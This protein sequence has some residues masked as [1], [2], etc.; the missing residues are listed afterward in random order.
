[1]IR[2]DLPFQAFGFFVFFAAGVLLG[3]AYDILR[4]WRALF[5]SERRSVFFQDF[6]FMGL[7][8]LFTFL[9][10]LAVNGGELRLFLFLSEA[11]GWVVWF[12]TVGRVT[13]GLFRK[14]SLFLYRSLFDPLHRQIS[15]AGVQMCRK[16]GKI[17]A[18]LKKHVQN[19]KKSLKRRGKQVYNKRE[20]NRKGVRG[21]NLHRSKEGLVDHES[22]RRAKT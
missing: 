17:W 9:I 3:A 19:R 18:P 12:N 10:N 11:L 1:M 6:F 14:L 15:H 8:A 22:R 2:S 7:A 21:G 13:V 5:R 16:M 4:I 20:K